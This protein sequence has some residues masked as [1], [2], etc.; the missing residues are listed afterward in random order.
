MRS[1]AWRDRD[2]RIHTP[3]SDPSAG[4]NAQVRIRVCCCGCA[5]CLSAAL[6]TS[7]E[8]SKEKQRQEAAG[9]WRPQPHAQSSRR[10]GSGSPHLW[11]TR[12]R[13]NLAAVC[14]V[15]TTAKIMDAFRL[16][17]TLEEQKE[18]DGRAMAIHTELVYAK[19]GEHCL[20]GPDDQ[21]LVTVQW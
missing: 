16:E 10:S 14:P 4:P 6:S 21:G 2:I 9:L 19:S 15:H 13:T 12:R 5:R 20:G 8:D 17:G 1:G 18:D 7:T 11:P 3:R